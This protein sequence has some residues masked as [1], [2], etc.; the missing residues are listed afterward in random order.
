MLTPR[1]WDLQ[2]LCRRE[3]PTRASLP[4]IIRYDVIEAMNA[5]A[6]F[7]LSIVSFIEK[8]IHRNCCN[9]AEA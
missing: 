5:A 3:R 9:Q 2:L 7:H 4:Y 1:A 8:S 6:W